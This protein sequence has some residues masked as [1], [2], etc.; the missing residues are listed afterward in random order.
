MGSFLLEEQDY[1]E[2]MESVVEPYLEDRK[3]ELWFAR[4]ED[5]HIY[6]V[7]Y[8]VEKPK[9]VVVIS[10]GFTENAEKYKEIIYYFL[11][12][13]YHVYLPEHCGHGRS[14]RLVEDDSL[15]H[16]DHARRYVKDFIYVSKK[17]RAEQPKL[18][19]YLFAH[20]MGGGIGAATIAIE[21]HLYRKAVLS[22]PM[23]RIK[24]GKIPWHD[25]K[26]IAKAFCNAG[27]SERYVIGKKPFDG[28]KAM[29]RSSSSFRKQHEYYQEK[30]AD[31]PLLQSNSPSYGWVKAAVELHEYLQRVAYKKIRIPVLLF[32][33]EKDHL[34]SRKEQARFILKLRS[35]GLL[36]AKLVRVPDTKHEVFN[37]KRKIARGYWNMVFR[38]FEN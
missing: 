19:L 7:R 21:P 4:E 24:A 2:K 30:R 8:L 16:V 25:I 29:E 36:T 20:S 26:R 11:K 15:V 17:V 31:N 38:F 9:G 37:S 10:H 12:R 13:Q 33:A 27:F 28:P 34:V 32:Q 18:P 22:S 23:I 35:V 3:T 1:R 6:C 5:K 14:Y